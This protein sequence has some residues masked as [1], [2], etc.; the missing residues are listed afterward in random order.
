MPD[1]MNFNWHSS[2]FE[3]APDGKY[4]GSVCKRLFVKWGVKQFARRNKII[5]S[6][7]DDA[8]PGAVCTWSWSERMSYSMDSRAIRRSSY[9]KERSGTYINW[10]M[11]VL[12]R[13]LA[14]RLFLVFRHLTREGR[15]QTKLG[16][17][18]SVRL[19]VQLQINLVPAR[20]SLA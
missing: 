11:L 12:L 2:F 5:N 16:L 14:L 13:S 17:R 7:G 18:R 6:S 10:I 19:T 1:G 3:V 4:L 15:R 20:D 8:F 9:A